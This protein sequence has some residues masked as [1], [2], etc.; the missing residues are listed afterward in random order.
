MKKHLFA[1]ATLLILTA[2]SFTSPTGNKI[3]LE[4]SIGK[5]PAGTEVTIVRGEVLV[6]TWPD[7]G[8]NGKICYCCYGSGGSYI[9]KVGTGCK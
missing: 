1:I 8:Y 5:I 7:C 4:D 3:I 9:C 2:S 6:N